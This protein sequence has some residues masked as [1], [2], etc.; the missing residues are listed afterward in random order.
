VIFN[1]NIVFL[2]KSIKKHTKY[3]KM[4]V[5]IQFPRKN[6]AEGERKIKMTNFWLCIHI[7]ISWEFF[8]PNFSKLALT[9]D[10]KMLVICYTCCITGSVSGF[11]RTEIYPAPTASNLVYIEFINK[12]LLKL[13]EF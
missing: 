3:Y 6:I 4:E 13:M 9:N 1:F 10:G 11:A 8:H 5:L 7:M 2:L 12:M